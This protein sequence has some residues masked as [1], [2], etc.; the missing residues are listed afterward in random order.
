M[1]TYIRQI[2]CEV[3]RSV[4]LAEGL[5]WRYLAE[6]MLNLLILPSILRAYTDQYVVLD[7]FW[8]REAR[9]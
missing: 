5:Y 9:A 8:L 7:M 3:R 4:K 6:T 1:K 2:G